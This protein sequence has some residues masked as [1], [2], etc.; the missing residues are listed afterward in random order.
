MEF[1]MQRRDTLTLA[2][3]LLS[4]VVSTAL[5]WQTR[6]DL[7]ALRTAQQQLSADVAALRNTPA[8]DVAGAPSLGRD[9]A[10]VTL[11]EFSDYECPFCI[12]HFSE[13]M[14]KIA[15]LVDQGKLRYVFKDFPIASLHPEA[16][17]A[18]EAARCAQDQNRFWQLHARLFSPAGTH[19]ESAL[20]AH[21]VEAG[22]DT[23][24]FRECL[25]SR[26]HA[27]HVQASVK[28]AVDLG[29]NGTPS[30]FL[31]VRD[32][33]TDRVDVLHTISGAQPFS[34]FEEAI[35]AVAARVV[36]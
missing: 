12:R 19:T 33:A 9:D 28:S 17:R 27:D 1:T 26:R 3:I 30:F 15:A 6:R 11:V 35:A 10:V 34:V 25:A 24:Q 14:P 23:G 13:T 36:P 32:R 31:G 29:A 4:L 7:G 22:L 18:H 5:W 8:I 21:A 2:L 16:A 20:E